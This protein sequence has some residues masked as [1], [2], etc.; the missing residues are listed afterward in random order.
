MTPWRHRM[1]A[2]IFL[3]GKISQSSDL[4]AACFRATLC[5]TCAPRPPPAHCPCAGAQRTR[6]WRVRGS[7]PGRRG[8]VGG[9]ARARLGWG[10]GGQW[11]CNLRGIWRRLSF[12]LLSCG[13]CARSSVGKE[14]ATMGRA[15]DGMCARLGSVCASGGL[16]QKELW[17]CLQDQSAVPSPVVERE[18]GGM[19]RGGGRSR[20]R[21]RARRAGAPRHRRDWRAS[22]FGR[23]GRLLSMSVGARGLGWVGRGLACARVSSAVGPG[24]GVWV[25]RAQR[26]GGTPRAL[27]VA[28][29]SASA[30]AR[31]SLPRVLSLSLPPLCRC[32]C[33]WRS[34]EAARRAR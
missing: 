7:C 1:S 24:G 13:T 28:P 27:P 16:A 22:R 12:P 2:R 31:A 20:E 18:G 17:N 30:R 9:C 19:R 6:G 14:A 5:R 15:L 32:W 34:S 3:R 11:P 25:G 21:A 4:Y 26:R 33:A 29:L 10:G 23:V 8:E